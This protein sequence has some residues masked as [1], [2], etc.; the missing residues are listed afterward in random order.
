MAHLYQTPP[1]ALVHVSIDTEESIFTVYINFFE[2]RKF[3][4]IVYLTKLTDFLICSRLL[5][6]KL[7]AGKA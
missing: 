3:H 7:I 1:L 4:L 6:S 5:S 2:N